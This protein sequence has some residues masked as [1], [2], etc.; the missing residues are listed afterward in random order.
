MK[1]KAEVV[2]PDYAG[3]ATAAAPADEAEDKDEAEEEVAEPVNKV[4]DEDEDEPVNKADDE[5][6][7]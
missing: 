3:G 5:D 7:K 4:D 2:R 6:E 1:N